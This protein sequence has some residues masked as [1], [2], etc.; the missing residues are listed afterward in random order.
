M[1]IQPYLS[2]SIKL[3]FDYNLTLSTNERGIVYPTP[4]FDNILNPYCINGI[5]QYDNTL[6]LGAGF[7]DE[8]LYLSDAKLVKAISQKNTTSKIFQDFLEN[9]KQYGELF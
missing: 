1:S 6:G 8:S 4:S 7:N 9:E 5:M 2:P 3:D